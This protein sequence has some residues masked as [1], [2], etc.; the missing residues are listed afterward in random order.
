MYD[1]IEKLCNQR[2]IKIGRLC[3]DLKI[4][5]SVLSELKSGRTKRLSTETLDKLSKYFGVSID[6]FVDNNEKDS[7]Y[8][9]YLS[10]HEIELIKAYR[11]HLSAQPFVDKLLN[12]S[13]EEIKKENLA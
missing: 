4:H 10:E 6:Y 11:S 5:R 7:E 1:K 9:F 3:Q 13:S 8:N 2:G 12:I